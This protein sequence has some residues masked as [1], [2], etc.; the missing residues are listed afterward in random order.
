MK[1]VTI[2]HTSFVSVEMLSR[3][4]AEL[5]PE[6][7]VHHIVD[8]T[9]LPEIM[10]SGRVTDTVIKRFCAYA[11]QAEAAGADMIFNQ[12]SSAGPAADVAKQM[13]R[14]PL[15]KV[16]EAMAEEAVTL[17]SKIAVV[18]TIGT[19]LRPSTELIR[20]TAEQKKKKVDVDSI[21]LTEAY[22]A[23]FLQKDAKTHNRIIL[24]KIREIEKSYDVICLAQGSMVT[25]LDDLKD[26]SVP[27][28]TS[29]R[30]GVL[31]ARTGLGY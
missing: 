1:K 30:L 13:L 14:I 7:A 6:V 15:L 18:A 25:L 10:A 3:L 8:D 29:P 4:F 2:I 23:L 28:L 12:C 5:V 17:G 19:T 26:V 31:K 16:D 11:V 21:L 9:L 22:E 27:L 24:S 20:K